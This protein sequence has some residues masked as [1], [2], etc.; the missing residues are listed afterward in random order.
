MPPD[1]TPLRP[2]CRLD[3][4]LYSDAALI[5][6]GFA[7]CAVFPAILARAKLMGRLGG[8]LQP[9]DLDPL[10]LARFMNGD[11][12]NVTFVTEGIEALRREGKVI[13]DGFGTVEIPNWSRYQ[14]DPSNAERQARFREKSRLAQELPPD[15]DN[16]T[17]RYR[18][19]VTPTGRDVTGQKD[20]DSPLPPEPRNVT[21]NGHHANGSSNGGGMFASLSKADQA[22][23][24]AV[25]E[26]MRKPARLPAERDGANRVHAMIRAGTL[27]AEQGR[28]LID[29]AELNPELTEV[30]RKVRLNHAMSRSQRRETADA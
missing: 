28:D 10:I 16:V 19:E 30:I 18:N 6:G 3:A 23:A 5:R 27:T 29:R 12:S 14:G 15:R 7:A 11:A 24:R 13:D 21:R 17:S 1:S 20:K 25:V 26:W 4:A 9:D 22:V 8:R 2:W